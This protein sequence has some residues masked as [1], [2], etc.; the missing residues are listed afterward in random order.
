MLPF[1]LKLFTNAKPPP[2]DAELLRLYRQSG[3]L[4]HLGELFQRHS[5]MVYLVC[6]KYLK[7]EEESKDATMQLF[8]HLT[9]ALLKHEVDNF[10]SWLYATAKNHCLMKLRPQKGATGVFKEESPPALMENHEPLHLT[11]AE[12]AEETEQLLQ[13]ALQQLPTE[14]YTCVEL[15]Y[16]QQKSYAEIVTLTGYE[17]NKVKSY[18]Q[19]GK[20]NL[21]IYMEKHHATR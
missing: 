19:N 7:D 5:E 20:R 18:I 12:Q 13:Q 9:T 1:F 4:E 3:E 14:Q 6:L 15:F 17:L 21:K 16:L 8:E 11:E 10:K 2:P